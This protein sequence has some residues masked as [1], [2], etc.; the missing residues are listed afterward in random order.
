MYMSEQE[1]NEE[2]NSEETKTTPESTRE[3]DLTESAPD[4]ETSGVDANAAIEDLL[5]DPFSE[6]T[7]MPELEIQTAEEE[8]RAAGQTFENLPAEQQN[9]ARELAQQ[10]D[11]TDTDAVLNYGSAAQQKLVI[12]H[13]TS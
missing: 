2:L 7:S 5:K 10:I 1:R 4:T 3:T 9:T 13:I 11:F 6:P 12:F 8:K